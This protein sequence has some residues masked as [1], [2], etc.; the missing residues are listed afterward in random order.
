MKA[1]WETALK[2]HANSEEAKA[3]AARLKELTEENDR[4]K[5]AALLQEQ[6]EKI[7]KALAEAKLPEALVSD[8]FRRSLL[9]ED[10]AEA[11]KALIEDRAA[12][13]ATPTPTGKP[14]SKPPGTTEGTAPETRE[15]FVESILQV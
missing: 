15:G 6:R 11:R 5:A 10:D 13:K 2:E 4:F 8:V 14:K 1:I 3:T 7:D 9:A 12:L